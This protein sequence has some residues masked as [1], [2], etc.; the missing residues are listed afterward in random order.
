MKTALA[1]FAG[2]AALAGFAGEA[3]WETLPLGSIRATG[4]LHEQLMAG[5]SGMGGHL[6]ELEPEII[7]KPF[8]TRDYDTT[9]PSCDNNAGW[10]SELSGDYW[11]GLVELAW[12]SGDEE[13]IAKADRW[14]ARVLELQQGEEDGYLGS[15]RRFDDQYDDFHTFGSRLAMRALLYYYEITGERKYLKAVHEGLKWFA[16]TWT[17]EHFTNECGPTLIEQMAKVHLLA[18]DRS[19]VDW[20]DSYARWIDGE[21]RRTGSGNYFRRQSLKLEFNHVGNLTLRA[22]LPALLWEAGGETGSLLASER[23][24]ADMD[25][26]IGWQ[27]NYAPATDYELVTHPAVDAECENCDFLYYFENFMHLHRLAGKDGY[28]DRAERIVFN[29]AMGARRKDDRAIAYMSTPNQFRATKT[30]HTGHKTG[31]WSYLGV[32]A[33]NQNPV[34][35]AANSVRIWPE[36]V[37]QAIVK[38]GDDYKICLYGPMKMTDGDAEIEIETGYPFDFTVLV[39]TRNLKGRLRFRVPEWADEMAVAETDE[40]QWKVVFG[41]SPVVRARQDRNFGNERLRSVELGPLVFVQPL[42]ELWTE[43]EE[44]DNCEKLPPGWHWYDVVCAEKPVVY[45]MPESVAYDPGTIKV[46]RRKGDALPWVDSP[47]RL[48][49]PMVRAP[50]A[51]DGDPAQARYN[52]PPAANPVKVDAAAVAEPV[53][54]VPYGCTALRVTCFPLAVR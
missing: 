33:P 39:K 16:K 36:Y 46:V 41:V 51:Y 22:I 11:L 48:T 9:K 8:V 17:P 34:C 25:S 13:L 14:V 52:P 49:V 27:A 7:G 29:A 35:C 50:E 15:F 20:C 42:K 12:T 21:A 3:K 45:A 31:D 4:W 24:I 47:L 2:L 10:C 6:D 19:L 30:S 53:E 44:A 43:V 1:A 18:G 54:F 26:E 28:C 37:R 40:G 38:K 23:H 32:Y 5:K